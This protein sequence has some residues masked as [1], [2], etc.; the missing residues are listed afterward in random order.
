MVEKVFSRNDLKNAVF[1]E[2]F[3]IYDVSSASSL[4]SCRPKCDSDVS[5][6]PILQP[7][8]PWTVKVEQGKHQNSFHCTLQ[9][10]IAVTL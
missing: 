10:P 6:P 1:S 7:F 5:A 8:V 3:P 2:S 4:E 9:N